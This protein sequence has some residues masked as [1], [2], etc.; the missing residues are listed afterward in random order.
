MSGSDHMSSWL[1]I[2]RAGP[3]P[4]DLHYR[5]WGQDGPLV[6]LLHELGG[7]AWSWSGIAPSVA[8]AGF[9]LV[10]FDQRGSGASEKTPGPY[11][12]DLL[13]DDLAEVCHAFSP[14]APVLFG[15]LAMGS[16]TGLRF[17][18]RYPERV[19]GLFLVSPAV[20]IEEHA[21]SYLLSRADRV[22]REGMRA[23]LE[24]S[25][26]NAF[27]PFCRATEAAAGYRNQYLANCPATYAASSR[28]LAEF[29]GYERL[30]TL[31]TPTL[32]ISGVHDFI[33]PPEHGAALKKLIPSARFVAV[34][35]GHFPPLQAPK[36]IENLFREF[37]ILN[38]VGGSSIP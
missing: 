18:Q 15:G 25:F 1:S 12:I 32:L 16:V 30:E 31:T 8:A 37:L 34:E 26:E 6:V 33:W 2:R 27:P 10:A 14:D 35:A 3:A 29:V 7:A 28:A 21:R 9:R 5:A 24:A 17:A 19:A 4:V 11:S 13:A 38:C 23:V 20:E 22:E 36:T